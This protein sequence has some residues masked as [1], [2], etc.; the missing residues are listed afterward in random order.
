[1]KKGKK[2]TFIK[3]DPDLYKVYDKLYDRTRENREGRGYTMDD[4]MSREQFM[5]EYNKKLKD[6]NILSKHGNTFK[7]SIEFEI[8]DEQVNYFASVKQ[9]QH[10]QGALNNLHLI[11]ES[12][13]TPEA[14]A[15]INRV[16]TN[17]TREDI[18]RGAAEGILTD[19]YKE[20]KNRYP[21]LD[22]RELGLKFSQM[23]FGSQ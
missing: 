12:E 9:A 6:R 1:M 7:S 23:Y 18:R 11:E 2:Q 15:I 8:V 4:K 10:I 19:L 3:K 22:Y 21:N 14:Q 16:D 20:L 17:L 5:T 13:L